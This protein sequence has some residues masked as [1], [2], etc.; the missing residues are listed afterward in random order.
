MRFG[1]S[2]AKERAL[3]ERLA[4]LG[5]AE[6]DLVERFVRASGPGGQNVNKVATAVYLKHTPSGI[7]V[8]AQEERSQALNRYRARQVLADRYEAMV[9]RRKTE[10][11]ARIARLR[12]QKKRRS[13]RAQEKVLQDK[14]RTGA[15]KGLRTSAGDEE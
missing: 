9:L 11:Q 8:K 14:R 15:R 2:A 6:T 4:R 13:R 7:E 10:E 1:V 3:G 12:K 5:I